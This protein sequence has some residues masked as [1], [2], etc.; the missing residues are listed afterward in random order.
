[1]NWRAKSWRAKKKKTR[2]QFSVATLVLPQA[3]T[4]LLTPRGQSTLEQIV[5]FSSI[6]FVLRVEKV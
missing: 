2:Q 5:Q 4:G 6:K 1:M 3:L